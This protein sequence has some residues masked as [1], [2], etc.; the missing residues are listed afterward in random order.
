MSSFKALVATETD[1]KPVVAFRDLT[2]ADLPAGEVLVRVA[3]SGLNYKD[4]LA[5]NGNRG[6]VMRKF[7]MVPGI[8]LAGTVVES[9]A[10]GF[11]PGDAVAATGWGLSETNWGGYTQRARL[12]AEWLVKLPVALDVKRAMAIGTAGFTA[13]LAVMALEDAGV[14]PGERAVLVT[15][16]AGG[17]GSVAVALLARLGFKVAAATGR[18]ETHDYLRNLGATGF[19]AR[20]DLHKVGRP[21][22]SERWAG[23]VDTVGSQTLAM[24]LSQTARHGAVAACGLAGGSDLPTTVLPFILRGVN[25]LG[26]DSVYCPRPRREAAWQRLARDLPLDKLDAMTRVVP[27]AEL[28]ALSPAILKGQIRGRTV[29]DVN[30]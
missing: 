10:A 2:D 8:D 9:R 28:L 23:T 14:R 15:G 26:I 17:V 4:G 16:A 1:G 25:L 27:F 19:V 29:I 3:Y 24:V 6:K 18:P 20:D 21:L 22:E 30:R 7:P 13:M 11:K 5:L 12:A